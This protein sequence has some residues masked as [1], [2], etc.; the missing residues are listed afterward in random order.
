MQLREF[1]GLRFLSIYRLY[2][3]G[4]PSGSQSRAEGARVDI[5][6]ATMADPAVALVIAVGR[7]CGFM[8][9]EVAVPRREQKIDLSGPCPE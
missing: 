7:Q 2:W 1:R 5:R 3:G 4:R 6:A 9:S 8:R